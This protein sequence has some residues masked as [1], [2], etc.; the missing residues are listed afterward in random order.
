MRE[1]LNV[2]LGA[3]PVGRALSETLVADGRDVR[4]VTRSGTAHV[5]SGVDVVAADVSDSDAS[6][7]ACA[8]AAMIFGCVGLD[9]KAWAEKWPPMMAG[10]LAGAEAAGARFVF[11]DNCYVYGP[12][13]E[14]M[15]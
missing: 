11:M 13:T 10:M 7:K 12:V 2:V 3:G 6:V 5:P 9:Y 1:G 15:R 4:V 8:G 14:P